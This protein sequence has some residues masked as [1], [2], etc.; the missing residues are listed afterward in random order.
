[1]IAEIWDEAVRDKSRGELL[2]RSLFALAADKDKSIRLRAIQELLDRR[3][4]RPT[5]ALDIRQLEVPKVIYVESVASRYDAEG[6][7]K[8]G[9]AGELL[10]KKATE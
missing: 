10:T 6:N 7:L 9:P 5:Q 3:L 4:G 2:I 1:L 8:E